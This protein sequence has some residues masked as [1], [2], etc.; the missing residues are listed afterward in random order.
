MGLLGKPSIHISRWWFQIFF[1]FTPTWGKFPCSLIFFKGVE[2]H[3]LDIFCPP[4]KITQIPIRKKWV[5]TSSSRIHFLTKAS[6]V[7]LWELDPKDTGRVG[8]IYFSELI[9][10]KIVFFHFGYQTPETNCLPMNIPIFPGKYHQNAGFSVALLVYRSV[11]EL[12]SSES[13]WSN[14]QETNNT[15]IWS[16]LRRVRLAGQEETRWWFQTFFIFTLTRGNDSI[17]L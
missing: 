12:I 5:V 17:W 2:N 6:L 15:G 4:P 7:K 14:K 9:G 10:E 3:Q 1:I 16:F 13:E 11:C 8:S